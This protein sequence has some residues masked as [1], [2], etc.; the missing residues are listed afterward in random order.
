MIL[1]SLIY[2]YKCHVNFVFS[3]KKQT[4][5]TRKLL[6]EMC[7]HLQCCCCLHR[8]S[9]DEA[10]EVHTTLRTAAGIFKFVKVLVVAVVV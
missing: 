3:L 9:M 6:S 5:A 2:M 1:F 10:K 8:V 7:W 4:A